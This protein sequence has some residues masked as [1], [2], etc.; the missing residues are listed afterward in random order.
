MYNL[1]Y[2]TEEANN[3]FEIARGVN[4]LTNGLYFT[5]SLLVILIVYMAVFKR[6]KFKEVLVAG[7]FFIIIIAVLF[8]AASLVN[9][10]F[11][12]APILLFFASLIVYYFV[13][14]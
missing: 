5:L 10:T 2:V 9:D 4:D 1:T 8:R 11:L 12:I 13:S 14:D 3:L 6:E 7:S